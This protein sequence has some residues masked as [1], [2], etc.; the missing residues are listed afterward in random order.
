MKCGFSSTFQGREYP[1]AKNSGKV[2]RKSAFHL[3]FLL[4]KS[5]FG[6]HELQLTSDT[7]DT[8]AI[9]RIY[10]EMQMILNIW[11]IVGPM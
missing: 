8:D 6:E 2:L 11:C 1:W 4:P 10:L 3:L 9:D 7:A 5:S